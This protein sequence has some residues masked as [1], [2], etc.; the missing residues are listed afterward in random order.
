MKEGLIALTQRI[1][2]KKD[3][4]ETRDCLDQRWCSFL[5]KCDFDFI[6]IPNKVKNMH[7]IYESF[8]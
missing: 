4:S 3:I 6:G 2:I 8:L 1:E 5:N 7:R